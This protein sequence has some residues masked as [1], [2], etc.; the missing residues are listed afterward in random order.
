MLTFHQVSLPKS[1][2][3]SLPFSPTRATCLAHFI[4][5]ALLWTVQTTQL[6]TLLSLALSQPQ[7]SYTCSIHASPLS[8]AH[9][10]PEELSF[11]FCKRDVDI[12]LRLQWTANEITEPC[13]KTTF[14]C[15][16][17]VLRLQYWQTELR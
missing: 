14:C 8:C 5:L 2:I 13:T 1:C 11:P 3:H 4:L 16:T 17:P 15:Y 12:L 10:K 7:H 9:F 6:L